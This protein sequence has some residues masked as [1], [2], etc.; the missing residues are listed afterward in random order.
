MYKIAFDIVGN[1]NGIKNA[2][3]ASTKFVKDNK[4]F[5][6]TLVGP[7]KEIKNYYENNKIDIS[8]LNISII[9][10]PNNF[11]DPKNIRQSLHEKTAMNDAID[12]VNNNKCDAVLSSGDS[13][14]FLALSS[15]KLKKIEGISRAAFMPMMPTI[16]GKK[17]FLLDVGANINTTSEYLVEWAKIA[18][19]FAEVFFEKNNPTVSLLNIGTEDFKGLDFVR[20]ANLSLKNQNELNYIGFSEPRDILRGLADVVVID[21]YGGNLVLKSLE[22]AILSFKDLLKEKIMKKSI[23]KIGYLLSKGAYKD[24][25]ETLDYRNVGAAWVVGLNG[26]A[27]KSHGGSDVKAYLGALNQIKIGLEKNILNKVKERIYEKK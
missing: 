5:E 13:G 1:D 9:N 3:E 12:L 23:R 20:E 7:E 21:G 25:A 19:I 24:V 4:N 15:F 18:S 8:K 27:I 10:N 2:L 26:M 22:G 16:S 14:M 11:E 6:I 17:F